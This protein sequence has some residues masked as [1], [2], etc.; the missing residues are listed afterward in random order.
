MRTVLLTYRTTTNGNFRFYDF[1][2]GQ[3]IPWLAGVESL[4][5]AVARIEHRRKL[6]GCLVEYQILGLHH[7]ELE[8]ED[9]RNR[10]EYVQRRLADREFVVTDR[11]EDGERDATHLFCIL[12]RQ[13]R[14]ALNEAL[15]DRQVI[16]RLNKHQ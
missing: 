9:L 4:E 10:C 6:D 13:T 2:S 8:L 14:S 7:G 15:V 16:R 5:V 1:E 12:L 3:V 11:I